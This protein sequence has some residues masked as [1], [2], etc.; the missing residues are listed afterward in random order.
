MDDLNRPETEE[1]GMR[2]EA[3]RRLKVRRQLTAQPAQTP[4]SSPSPSSTPETMASTSD[5]SPSS[6]N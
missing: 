2:A 1:D 4:D 5:A 6:S 3:L